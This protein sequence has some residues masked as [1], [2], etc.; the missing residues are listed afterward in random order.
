[1][2]ICHTR[3]VYIV[4]YIL[5][6]TTSDRFLIPVYVK[7]I[8]WTAV[9]K[10]ETDFIRCSTW[11]FKKRVWEMS[12]QLFVTLHT[13]SIYPLHHHYHCIVYAPHT[14]LFMNSPVDVFQAQIKQ[15]E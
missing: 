1:M 13:L 8:Q 3:T 2:Y 12:S 5:E 7:T 6:Y 11:K 4:K 9:G 15:Q 10:Y 14:T